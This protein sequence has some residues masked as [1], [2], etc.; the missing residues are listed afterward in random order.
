LKQKQEV[1]NNHEQSDSEFTTI[2]IS[3]E[4]Y[5]DL[6]KHGRFHDTH[7]DIIA[8]LLTETDDKLQPKDRESF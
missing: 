4:V 3:R 5:N 2:R 8:R 6:S 1:R 7:S